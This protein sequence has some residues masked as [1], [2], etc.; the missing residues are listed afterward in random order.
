[1]RTSEF[2]HFAFFK[3]GDGVLGVR[4]NEGIRPQRLVLTDSRHYLLRVDLF[5]VPSDNNLNEAIANRLYAHLM[6]TRRYGRSRPDRGH[7]HM[8]VNVSMVVI[9]EE[10]EEPKQDF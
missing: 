9:E 7:S 6:A 5:G 1:M 3:N 10:T 2:L 4:S 8:D